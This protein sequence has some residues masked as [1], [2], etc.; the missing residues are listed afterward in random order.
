MSNCGGCDEITLPLGQDGVDG[1]NAFT[2]T[3]SQ[4]TQPIVG[5]SVSI[6]VSTLGQFSNAW[7]SPGQIIFI[8]DSSGN[9]GYYQVVSITGNDSIT[10]TNLGY[11]SNTSDGLPIL[12]GASVAPSGPIGATG[13]AGQ[14]GGNGQNGSQGPAGT[15]GSKLLVSSTGIAVGTNNLPT[16]VWAS[17]GLLGNGL[18]VF[19]QDNDKIVI[20]ALFYN[21]AGSNKGKVGFFNVILSA[22][23]LQSISSYFYTPSAPLLVL[24]PGRS[25]NLRLELYRVNQTTLRYTVTYTDS[26]GLTSSWGLNNTNL[27]ADDLNNQISILIQAQYS[28]NATFGEYLEC[29]QA[30]IT[31][32]KQ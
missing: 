22:Q 18:L 30:S 21:N 16:V 9:G 20:D 19:P 31:S 27:L 7:A 4:F 1:K 6:N 32:Y 8:V 23:S 26:T 2:R 10:I 15:P 24:N 12:S 25:A 17:Y 5:T 3:T 11:A 28:S 29:S 13:A 14:N